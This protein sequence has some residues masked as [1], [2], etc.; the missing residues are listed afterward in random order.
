[1]FIDEYGRVI[2]PSMAG[3]YTPRPISPA[4]PLPPPVPWHPAMI[5]T[6]Q[7]FVTACGAQQASQQMP[8]GVLMPV[9]DVQDVLT[10]DDVP[11][12]CWTWGLRSAAARR[13]R[14]ASV[15]S[16]LS[17]GNSIINHSVGRIRCHVW[18]SNA[19]VGTAACVLAP[20]SHS[21]E[22]GL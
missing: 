15:V 16:V 20:T 4:Q 9:S 22:T 10:P 11:V 5:P 19:G 8:A 12:R 6:Q 14:A 1:M 17:H 7:M 3:Q 21:C 18:R 13:A 2:S